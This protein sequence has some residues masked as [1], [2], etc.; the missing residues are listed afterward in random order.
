MTDT[1]SG[2]A[3][4]DSRSREIFRQIVETYLATGEPVGSRN[5][6]RNL[7]MTLSPASVR[8][9]M[10]DLEGAGLIYAPHTSAGRLPTQSGLRMFID[11]LMEIGDLSDKDRQQI[12]TQVKGRHKTG[13]LEEALTEASELISG[14][15]QCAGVVLAEKQQIRLK[16]TEFVR[17]DP[18]RALAVL[19]SDDG[20]VENR[21]I[22]LP[23]GLPA[24][25]LQE[26]SNYLNA[27]LAGLTLSEARGR[28]E[29]ERSTQKAELDELAQRVIDAGLATWSGGEQNKSLIVRG[30][31][32][33]L[34]DIHAIEDLDRI[35]RLFDDLEAKQE[36]INLLGAADTAE[37]VRIFI[38]SES[39]L[40]S[41][42]RLVP[43]SSAVPRH[44]EQ[45]RRRPRRDRADPAEL[46][47]DY[48]HGRFHSQAGWQACVLILPAKVP[49]SSSQP[50]NKTH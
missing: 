40:F 19:V 20:R 13:T 9:V 4:L 46:R 49:I 27:K 12:E 17:L 33:L 24:S 42:S 39:R 16:H 34:T 31:S 14:L 10:S 15:S 37:G 6:S 47:P 2:L 22:D 23:P 32:N 18:A 29:T 7:P 30:Q 25:A 36:L 21:V 1:R 35:R 41:L 43:G 5:L 11:G 8:N 50:S 48:P 26:A 28:L 44:Q 38:G 3:D 45:D